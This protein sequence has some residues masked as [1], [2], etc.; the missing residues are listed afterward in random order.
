MTLLYALLGGILPALLWLLFW[1]REDRRRPEPRGRIF[2]AFAAGMTAVLIVLPIEHSLEQLPIVSTS[3]LI[4][5][6]AATE[7]LIKYL[8]A[9]FAALKSSDMDE[10]IDGIIYMITAALG[11]AALENTFFLLSPIAEGALVDILVTGNMRFIGATLLHT[12]ASGIVGVMI[13]FSYYRR[14]IIRIEYITAGLILAIA[15][16]AAFNLFIIHIPATNIIT[17]FAGVWVL[18]VGIILLFEK[19]KRVRPTQR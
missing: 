5:L 3:V 14:N 1:L 13:A 18:I 7:E 2:L 10:P 4:I 11:F 8:A 6:W 12:A 19:A 15:L 17:I 16:H 9:Y